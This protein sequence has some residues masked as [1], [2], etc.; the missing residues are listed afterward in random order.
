V[1]E[2]AA[3]AVL[4]CSTTAKDSPGVVQLEENTLPDVVFGVL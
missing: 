2:D 4:L 3:V 1:D